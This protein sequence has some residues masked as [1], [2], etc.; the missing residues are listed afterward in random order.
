MGSSSHENH[1]GWSS[2]HLFTIHRLETSTV[3]KNEN[4]EANFTLFR[5]V[6][7]A[8]ASLFADEAYQKMNVER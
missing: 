8:A 3:F 1:L 4:V 7:L 6:N 2:L 5:Q